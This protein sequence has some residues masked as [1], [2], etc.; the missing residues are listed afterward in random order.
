MAKT[1]ADLLQGSWVEA[2]ATASGRPPGMVAD[3]LDRHDLR[4]QSLIPR[5]VD[6]TVRRVAMSGAKQIEEET[7]PF[8]FAWDNL[9]PGLCLLGSGRNGRGK[10]ALFGVMRWLLRGTDPD[11][12]PSDVL[13]WIHQASMDFDLDGVPHRIAIDRRGGFHGTLTVTGAG[14]RTIFEVGDETHFASA[15]SDFMLRT[16][17]LEPVTSLNKDGKTVHHRWPALFGAFHIGTDYSALIGDAVPLVN[18]MMNMFAGFPHAVPVGQLTYVTSGLKMDA[19]QEGQASRAVAEHAKARADRIR[20]ELDALGAK[21]TAGQSAAELLAAMRETSDELAVRF[22]RL[23]GLRRALTE[24]QDA[25]SA[26]KAEWNADRLA[27]RHFQEDR[28]ASRIFRS[29]D[30]KCC[31]RCDQTFGAERK[32]REAADHSCLVCGEVTPDED[33]AGKAEAKALLE[34]NERASAQVNASAQEA[35]ERARAAVDE[36]EARVSEQERKLAEVTARQKAASAGAADLTRRA[37]LE[38]MLA[39]AETDS[40]AADSRPETD[41]AAIAKACDKVFRQRLRSE[42]EGIMEELQAEIC[43][44]LQDFGVTNLTR[45]ELNTTPH[46]FLRK[47]YQ[48]R[49]RIAFGDAS[50][51]EKLRIKIAFIV[52]LMKVGHRRGIGSHPGLLFIDTPGA[53]ETADQDLA[54]LARRLGSLCQEVP[55]LQIFVATKEFDIFDTAAR[56]AI[57][58]VATGD[59]MLW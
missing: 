47:G 53:Q 28:E 19:D 46:L 33:E 18:R 17:A 14:G 38:A 31:P 2:I 29:M 42:Q 4:A 59:D 22:A 37:V 52:A 7:E 58:L 57:R 23:P 51:G 49:D 10:T 55:N 40:G 54:A 1:K 27:L 5:P 25:A 26:A 35:E 48:G 30:P 45:V 9:A 36:A 8:D 15:V 43:A 32:E 12:I 39:D 3:F 20:V 21:A 24:A 6:L 13:G 34:A 56:P 50:I 16:L 11:E 41:E 44:L